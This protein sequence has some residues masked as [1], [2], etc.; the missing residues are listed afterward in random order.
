MF[1][2]ICSKSELPEGGVFRF[3]P[4]TAEKAIV[5][6]NEGGEYYAIGDKCSH[7]NWSLAEGLLENCHLECVLHG[8]SFNLKT[9][10]PDKRPATKPVKVFTVKV[11]GDDILV[12]IES[13]V[14]LEKPDA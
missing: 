10:W 14:L 2:K 4:E 6:C 13:G 5:V 11:E 7:G 9:G 12:D 8:S 1:V 3:D